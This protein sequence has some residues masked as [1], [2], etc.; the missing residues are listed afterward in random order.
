MIFE[1]S[2]ACEKRF[3][4]FEDKLTSAPV[5][6]LL[7]GNERFFIYYNASRV[8]FGCVLI[9]HCKV[10]AYASRQLKVHDKSYPTHEA[11]LAPIV[12]S[13]KIW[14]HYVSGVHV[15]VFTDHESL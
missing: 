14:N 2:E 3:T 8:G 1:W 6:N 13:F 4:K 5:L 10:I 15:D 7:E 11:E 9:Y 12:F